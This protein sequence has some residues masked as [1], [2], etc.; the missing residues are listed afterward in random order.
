L[1]EQLVRGILKA[2]TIIATK[3]LNDVQNQA[4]VAHSI[5]A[6]FPPHRAT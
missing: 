4:I 5:R 2:R 3:N 6:A 1:V